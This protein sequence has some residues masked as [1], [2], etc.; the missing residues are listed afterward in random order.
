MPDKKSTIQL[1]YLLT[2]SQVARVLN[3]STM[4]LRRWDKKGL[5]KAIRVGS[6]GDRRYKREEIINILRSG[7][8]KTNQD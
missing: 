5:L 3:V 8:P 6:R 7:M 1:K 2:I 4:T